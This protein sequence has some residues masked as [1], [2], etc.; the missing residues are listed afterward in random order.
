MDPKTSVARSPFSSV[1][2]RRRSKSYRQSYRSYVGT[3]SHLAYTP[4]FTKRKLTTCRLAPKRC[5]TAEMNPE[6]RALL[7]REWQLSYVTPLYRFQHG[8]LKTYSRQ[9]AAFLVSE[10]QRGVAAEVGLE[11][12]LRV[13]FTLVAGMAQT[14]E[15]ADTVFIKIH[16]KTPLAL[17]DD[18]QKVLWS[19]WLTCVGG[20][21][22]YLRTLPE[23]FVCLPLFCS[24]GTEGLTALVKAWFQRTFDCCFGLLEINS[25]NLQWLAALWTD[26]HARTSIKQLKLVW[27]LPAE[28]P[29]EVIYAM[30]AQDASELWRSVRQPGLREEEDDGSVGLEE[31]ACF[32]KGLKSH[33]YRHFRVELP[34]GRLT[35]VSTALGSAKHGGRIKIS[36]SSYMIT[37]LTLLTECALLKMPI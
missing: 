4:G 21:P 5:S 2:Q 28:P 33:F 22:D 37:T 24:G 13:T 18:P 6:Q 26:C 27:S 25:V 11:S 1:V 7:V 9:L 14:E 20:D 29:M 16:S 15:E 23:D 12:T 3:M 34:A 8:H 31:V 36:N 19:G 17:P 32:F 35:Q 30:H 10:R